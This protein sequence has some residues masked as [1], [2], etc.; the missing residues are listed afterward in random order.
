MD[1]SNASNVATNLRKLNWEGALKSQFSNDAILYCPEALEPTD[2]F[3]GSATQAHGTKQVPTPT[4]GPPPV[5]PGDAFS[6]GSYGINGFLYYQ[7][8]AQ[9]QPPITYATTIMAGVKQVPTATFATMKDFWFDD[10]TTLDGGVVPAFVRSKNP[11]LPTTFGGPS[12]VPAFGDCNAPD[13][14]PDSDGT[15]FDPT[16]SSGN[17]SMN[18]G[19]Q[20]GTGHMLGRFC[21]DRHPGGVNIVFLDGHVSAVPLRDLWQ[22]RWN[23]KFVPVALGTFP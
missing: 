22:L 2:A 8:P 11:N 1:T 14:W 12:S 20:G 23:K 6:S 17:Y 4:P 18:I 15:T 16:P 13:S 9:M 19:D 3:Y 7:D 21:L 5:I 10:L